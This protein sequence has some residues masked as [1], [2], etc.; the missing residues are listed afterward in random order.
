MIE[1]QNVT[2]CDPCYRKLKVNVTNPVKGIHFEFA[3]YTETMSNIVSAEGRMH[4]IS[5]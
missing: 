2:I 1:I 3:A 5:T 4:S